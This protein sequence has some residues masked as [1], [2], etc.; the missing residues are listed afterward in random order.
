MYTKEKDERIRELEEQIAQLKKREQAKIEEL[1]NA[2]GKL[3]NDF[4]EEKD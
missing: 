2:I 1:K 3:D 4:K